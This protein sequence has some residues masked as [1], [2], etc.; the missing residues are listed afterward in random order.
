MIA[1]K[2]ITSKC[3]RVRMMWKLMDTT[4]GHGIAFNTNFK[5]SRID[6]YSYDIP[7]NNKTWKKTNL[8]I[9]ENKPQ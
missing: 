1:K 7:R 5:T 6:D 4:I 9:K 3:N 2:T 8:A